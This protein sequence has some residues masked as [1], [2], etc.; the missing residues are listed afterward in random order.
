[1]IR[2]ASRNAMA[3]LRARLDAETANLSSSE[4]TEVA[5]QLYAVADLLVGESRLRR[6]LGDPS[7][8]EQSRTQLVSQL[9]Q[10]KVL[11]AT[12]SVVTTAVALRWSSPWDLTDGIAEIGDDVLL[13]TAEIGGALPEVEDQLF[14]FERILDSQGELVTLLDEV[15]VPAERRTALLRDVVFGRVHPITQRLLE[16]V[17]ASPR[18]RSVENAIDDLLKAAAARRERSIARVLSAVPVT[19]SQEERLAQAL[20][21][22]YGRPIAVRTAVDPSIQGGLVVRIGDELIDGSVAGRFTAARAAL[23]GH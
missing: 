3:E 6:I 16:H 14:R 19:A 8:A 17:V 12:V 9:L 2:A 4:L 15:S 1:V 18:K 7:T 13:R 20:S 23:V 21:E 10:G 11:P 22:I 5:E